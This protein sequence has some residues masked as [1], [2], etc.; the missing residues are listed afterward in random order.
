MEKHQLRLFVDFCKILQPL[1]L[2]MGTD[3]PL[4]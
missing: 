4:I 3:R 2:H 1:E